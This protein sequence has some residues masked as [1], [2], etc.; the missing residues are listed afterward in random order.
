MNTG[1]SDSTVNLQPLSAIALDG[2]ELTIPAGTVLAVDLQL[3]GVSGYV[4][5]SSEP[6]TASWS[7]E[8]SGGVAFLAGTPVGG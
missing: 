8:F 4:V 1:P 7:V 3:L 2:E 5:T 6:V